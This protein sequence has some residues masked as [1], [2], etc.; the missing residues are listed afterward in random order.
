MAALC[1]G[2]CASLSGVHAVE[3]E[4]LDKFSVDGYTEL[5]GS[6]AVTGGNFAVGVSTLVV[7]GGNVGIGTAGPGGKVG[8]SRRINTH[9]YSAYLG[10]RFRHPPIE[11]EQSH[12]CNKFKR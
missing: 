11:R 5:R 3:W 6:A 1:S 9:R 8:C 2:L 4:V 10:S 7:K 12:S